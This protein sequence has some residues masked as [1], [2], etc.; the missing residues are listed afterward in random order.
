MNKKRTTKEYGLCSICKCYFDPYKKVEH[1]QFC[2][3]CFENMDHH[4][5]WVGKC[6]ANNNTFY[7]YGMLIDVVILYVFII[8]CVFVA[9]L[10]KRQNKY[11]IPS[12]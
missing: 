2:G 5:M 4:C 7:F 9:I 11:S 12:L 1:C 8:Y 3:V 10:E 6:V